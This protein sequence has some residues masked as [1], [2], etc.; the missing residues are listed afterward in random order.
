MQDL[1]EADYYV[2]ILWNDIFK[3]PSKRLIEL[4]QKYHKKHGDKKVH[5]LYVN[6]QNAYLWPLMT[7]EQREEALKGD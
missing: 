5:V 1:P 3:R 7:P 2:L 6:N 4:E